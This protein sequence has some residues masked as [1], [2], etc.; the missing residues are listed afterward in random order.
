MEFIL[1]LK[2][3]NGDEIAYDEA[4][5]LYYQIQQLLNN[6]NFERTEDITLEI[7]CLLNERCWSYDYDELTIFVNEE[8]SEL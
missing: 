6:E 7:A 8:L 5:E 1:N 2:N 3:Y 4:E